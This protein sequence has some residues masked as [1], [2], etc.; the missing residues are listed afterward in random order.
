M[1]NS[2]ITIKATTAIPIYGVVTS[3]GALASSNNPADATKII[4]VTEG[5]MQPNYY[6]DVTIVGLLFDP[7]W[8]WVP[9]GELYLNGTVLSQTPPGV[10]FTKQLGWALTAQSLLINVTP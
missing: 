1:T 10:G 2:K 5:A 4:G 8:T 3:R 6:Y 7:N 9:G